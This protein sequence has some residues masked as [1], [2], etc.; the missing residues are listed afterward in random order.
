MKI[1]LSPLY[2]LSFFALV[3]LVHEIH[4]WIHVLV[5]RAVCGCWGTKAFDYWT[6]CA[7]SWVSVSNQGNVLI[8]MAG[9]LFN[10]LVICWGWELMQPENELHQKSLGF[11]LVF[12]SLPFPR[13]MGALAG[14]GDETLAL[15]QIFLHAD[16]GNRHIVSLVG[17]LFVLILT[18][19][20][21]YRAFM[22]VAG[23]WGK[24]M[25]VAFLVLPGYIDRLVVSG[26]LNKMLAKGIL[27]HQVWTGFSQGIMVWLLLLLILLVVIGRYLSWAFEYREVNL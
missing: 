5:A 16:G 12:A 8:T 9:P 27:V 1:K 7:K 2:L 19:P 26:L 20:A 21:L 15:K 13:I 22:L 25:V 11:S 10:Y 4:D 6:L 14:G 24:L 23:L 3:F 18:L 17:L